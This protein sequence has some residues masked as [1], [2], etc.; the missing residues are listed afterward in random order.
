MRTSVSLPLH[1]EGIVCRAFGWEVEA[2]KCKVTM[3]A[4]LVGALAQRTNYRWRAGGRGIRCRACPISRGFLKKLNS[5][6]P[7]V[8]LGFQVRADE[9][10]GKGSDPVGVIATVGQHVP[11]DAINPQRPIAA[12]ANTLILLPLLGA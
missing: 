3:A 1:N 2:H 6:S 11:G 8:S 9:Q 7:A 10:G 5:V 12:D 4:D